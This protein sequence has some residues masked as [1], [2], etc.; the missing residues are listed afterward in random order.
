[1][2]IPRNAATPERN[3]HTHRNAYTLFVP[4]LGPLLAP[5]LLYGGILGGVLGLVTSR[6]T[7]EQ[8]TIHDLVN[9][10]RA[11]AGLPTILPSPHAAAKAQTWAE[12]LAASETL[13]HSSLP[14]GMPE[15]FR[16]IGENVGRGPDIERIH[17]A[18]MNSDGHRRNVLDPDY[19]WIGTGYARS[20]TGVVYVAVVF[21]RY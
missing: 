14:E 10:E 15:G 6:C 1:M 11:E 16:K 21:A 8:I 17:E 13:R 2:D 18:F 19:N 7:P 12:E 5:L 4:P 9:S 20:D 3:A